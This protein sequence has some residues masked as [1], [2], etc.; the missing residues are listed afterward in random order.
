[1]KTIS[2]PVGRAT[3]EVEYFLSLTTWKRD[4]YLT[5]GLEVHQIVHLQALLK[6][7]I[8]R[9]RTFCS[10]PSHRADYI[11]ISLWPYFVFD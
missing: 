2:D 4:F 10:M 7:M 11:D 1:M 3:M 5:A 9:A 6:S 8:V